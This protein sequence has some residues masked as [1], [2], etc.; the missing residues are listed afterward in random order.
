[1]Q[2]ALTNVTKHAPAATPVTVTLRRDGAEAVVTVVN[3]APQAEP[4]GLDA[5]PRPPRGLNPE[6]YGLVSLDERV[7]QAGGTLH[8]QPTGGGFAVNA[9]LPLTA[10]VSATPPGGTGAAQRELAVARRRVR[11]RMIH[12]VWLPAAAM[13]ALLLLMISY[14]ALDRGDLCGQDLC[15]GRTR[16]PEVAS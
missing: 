2:E 11:R 10:G 12:T 3:Q 13:A 16:H 7:R 14:R 1:M 8:V 15:A 6:G 4:Q 9:R 5:Q